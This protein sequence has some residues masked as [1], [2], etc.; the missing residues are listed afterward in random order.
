[1]MYLSTPRIPF[2]LIA[3]LAVGGLLMG[4]ASMTYRSGDDR[5]EVW[6]RKAE[7]GFDGWQHYLPLVAGPYLVGDHFTAA[8]LMIGSA[9]DWGLNMLSVIKDRP[10]LQDY[11]ARLIE[12]PAKQR[13]LALD[14]ELMANNA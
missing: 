13:Q 12:R 6:P 1:M 11:C 2:R 9:L 8:D 14:G 4:C 3:L 7:G 10:I 5:L